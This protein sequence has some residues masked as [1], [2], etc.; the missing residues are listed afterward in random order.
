MAPQSAVIVWQ[1][2]GFVEDVDCYFVKRASAF[3]L[4]VENASHIKQGMWITLGAKG[5]A[6]VPDMIAPYKES[7]MPETWKRIHGTD[8]KMGM[9]VEEHH[10][11]KSVQGNRITLREPVK[12]V[13]KASHGWT[14]SEY[15][16][17]A[18]IGVE[19]ICFQ[20]GWLGKYVH[21]RSY[22]DD[23]GWAA[24]K[25]N[26]VVDSWIRRCA[27]I[28][29]NMC[30]GV[31]DCA[32]TSVMQCVLGGTMGH[33]AFDNLRRSTG[34]LIGLMDDRLEHQKGLKDTTHGIG[35]AGSAV[36]SV[37]WRYTMQVDESFDM[38]G[39][40]PY[41]TL[42]DRIE[43]GNFSGSGGPVQSFPNHLQH[44]VA[45]NFNQRKAPTKFANHK[46]EYDFWGGRPSLVMPMLIGMYGELAPINL[47][48]VGL[49][50]SPGQPVEP[51]SLYEAQL[52]LRFGGKCPAWVAQAKADWAKMNTNLPNFPRGGDNTPWV[53]KKRLQ[54]IQMIL[55]SPMVKEY[56]D[57]TDP[58]GAIIKQW[59]TSDGQPWI[60]P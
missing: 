27:V 28:N 15:Q 45:W 13:I 22:T 50:E 37:F 56:F 17:I 53:A 34:I 52:A 10:L 30:L 19:D 20:G 39:N 41:A 9:E 35:V 18:E 29:F 21:H 59:P 48:T 31:D 5:Q 23:N 7:D 25:M 36:S 2:H 51:E 12:T 8:S 6:V 44:F 3:T 16:N 33:M 38:H 40:F 47:K 32:Y 11:V 54:T 60:N 26:N 43:G 4:T 57:K 49:Y 1:L 42:F 58:K 14:V 46:E 24:L 55:D